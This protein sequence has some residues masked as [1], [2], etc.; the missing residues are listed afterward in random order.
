MPQTMPDLRSLLREI[1]DRQGGNWLKAKVGDGP[2]DVEKRTVEL[3]FSSEEPYARWWG[4]EILDHSPGSADLSRL[5]D[6]ASCLY[7]H[8]TYRVE[9]FPAV[10]EEAWIGEDRIGRAVVRF[11]ST[12]DAELIFTKIREGIIRH[13]SVRYQIDDMVLVEG[14][15]E[16][17]ENTYRV[18]AWTPI[19]VSFVADPADHTVGVGRDAS[20]EAGGG[21]KPP[22]ATIPKEERTMP[23]ENILTPEAREQLL[24]EGRQAEARR[25]ND[26]SAMARN[27]G[28]RLGEET[29]KDLERQ[30]LENGKSADD[31][32]R[33]LFEQMGS[34]PPPVAPHPGPLDIP[35]SKSEHQQYSILR[36][37]R[38]AAGL[39]A[40]GG[41]EQ[42]VSDTIGKHFGRQ[43]GERSIFLP[44]SVDPS[45]KLSDA[46]R[47]AIAAASFAQRDTMVVGTSGVGGY[48]VQTTI[49]PLIEVIRNRMMVKKMG[50]RVMSGLTGNLAFPRQATSSTLYWTGENPGSDTTQ[51]NP[52]LEQP[53]LTP[54]TAMATNTVS[55]QLLLQS[56]LDAEMF[57]KD[58]LAKIN[59]V[60]LDN[61]ALNGSGS[62]N[63]PTGVRYT[64]G[65]GNSAVGGTNGAAPTWVLLN[66]IWRDI[67]I[68]SADYGKMGYLINGQ[69]CGKLMQTPVVASTDSKMIIENFPDGEGMTNIKG[70]RCGVSNQVPSTLTKGTSSGVCSAIFCGNWD[71]LLIGEFGAIELITDPYTKAKQG[72]VEIT[73]QMMVDILVRHPAS[74]AAMLDALSA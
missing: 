36:A 29:V 8:D 5:N 59:A 40:R 33:A 54:K 62:S 13:V 51:S 43:A 3:A 32:G 39:E 44:S 38:M 28:R 55:R 26:I 37:V 74:F 57:L 21:S 48:S 2:I 31:F 18:T 70:M 60:G 73:S 16:G 4:I 69:T 27:A 50:A 64:T 23:P 35:M 61:A 47:N 14:T 34:A 15:P 17:S 30:F 46:Q 6:G 42:E 49:G 53:S 56:S 41:I 58:D 11:A 20:P 24:T 52:T 45:L 67:A 72:L 12:A 1:N 19:H 7:G 22:V 71:D 68:D 25:R 65:I 10:V 66:T 9:H 63:Q